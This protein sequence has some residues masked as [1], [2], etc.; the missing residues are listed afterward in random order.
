LW[1]DC[2]AV[3]VASDEV[4]LQW[5]RRGLRR[6]AEPPQRVACD[7]GVQHTQACVHALRQ[8]LTSAPRRFDAR[9]VLSNQLVRY[10]I[11]P[12][13]D[14][15]Q[16]HAERVAAARPALR[17]TYGETSEAWQVVID[18]R[19][20]DRMLAAAIDAEFAKGITS[21]LADAGAS[22]LRM[23]P[24]FA[25][26]A[27]VA[28]HGA[29]RRGWIVVVERARIVLA[30]MAGGEFRVLRT[31][32]VRQNAH[33]ELQVLL[34][35]SRVLDGDGE[36]GEVVLAGEDVGP[37]YALPHAFTLRPVRLHLTALSQAS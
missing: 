16:G 4:R 23:E 8:A 19:G 12:H 26:A 22:R 36:A 27:N 14:A 33:E 18:D 9:V 3:F 29:T 11:V 13:A 5:H 17:S 20:G 32:R 10:A 6:R 7:T 24:L 21:A 30:A 37:A 25:V 15:L 1:R 35:R 2:A 34:E 28:A 31:H